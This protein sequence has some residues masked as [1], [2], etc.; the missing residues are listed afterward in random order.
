[1][2]QQYILTRWRVPYLWLQTS[3]HTSSCSGRLIT[4]HFA[5]SY[6][7]DRSD[8]VG[9]S[10]ALSESGQLAYDP[11]I[12]TMPFLRGVRLLVKT[13]IQFQSVPKVGLL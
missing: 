7:S 8:K 10:L 1:M 11:L 5:H 13:S 9:S 6:R 2:P 3:I 4:H 12:R